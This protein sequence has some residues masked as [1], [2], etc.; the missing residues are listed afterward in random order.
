MKKIIAILPL[1]FICLHFSFGQCSSVID[2][3]YTPMGSAIA[4]KFDTCELNIDIRKAEDAF[5]K[6][7]YNLTDY[8]PNND[9]YDSEYIIIV[10]DGVSTTGRFNCHGYAWIR[11]E[12]GIDRKIPVFDLPE[13]MA[14]FMNDG[15]YIEVFQP[16]FPA[17]V[18]WEGGAEAIHSTITTEHPGYVI[19]KWGGGPLCR[20]WW[21]NCPDSKGV[22]QRFFV[23]NCSCS[24]F[25]NE[26]VNLTNLTLSDDLIVR[27]CGDIH[28]ENVTVPSGLSLTLYARN[29]VNLD[30]SFIAEE[31][32]TVSI[33]IGDPYVISSP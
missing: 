32:S 6:L 22:I 11:T 4:A 23:K 27:S 5:Y 1:L 19:S 20:H 28:I 31:G 18:W 15:S 9:N 12:Q 30:H 7:N 24:D 13:E 2:S 29:G 10:Y 3:V 16:V 26:T 17:K 33:I 21:S 14:P 8:D 25:E